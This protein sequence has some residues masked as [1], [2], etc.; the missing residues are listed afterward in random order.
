MVLSSSAKFLAA[1]ACVGMRLGHGLGSLSGSSVH[2]ESAAM[3]QYVQH[4]RFRKFAPV[5]RQYPIFEL[6]EDDDVLLDVSVSDEGVIE[7][8]LHAAGSGKICKLDE[9]HAILLQGKRLLEEEMA[10]G[11]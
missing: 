7:V 1:S 6:L 9:L 5:D 3:T 8:A 2:R 4:V 10:C 11:L